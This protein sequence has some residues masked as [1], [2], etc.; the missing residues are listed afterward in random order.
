MIQ[1]FESKNLLDAYGIQCLAHDRQL[2]GNPPLQTTWCVVEKGG[3]TIPHLHVEPEV[4]IALSGSAEVQVGKEVLSFEKGDVVHLPSEVKHCVRNVSDDEFTFLSVYWPPEP[5]RKGEKYR[6]VAAPPT[7]NGRL[8]LGHISGPYL[9]AMALR[10][11]LTQQGAEVE[12]LCGSDDHQSYVC[13]AAESASKDPAHFCA[14]MK[15]DIQS[16]FAAAGIEWDRLVSPLQNESYREAVQKQFVQLV[17]EGVFRRK[18]VA[19]ALGESSGQELYGGYI[20]GQCP[21]CDTLSGGGLCEA[22]GLPNGSTDLGRFTGTGCDA[23]GLISQGERFVLPLGDYA[24]EL[25]AVLLGIEMPGQLRRKLLGIVDRGLPEMVVS[26]E[27]P[28]GLKATL[29]SDQVV[30]EWIEMALAYAAE[31]PH[32]RPAEKL[33]QCFGTDNAYYYGIVHLAVYLALGREDLI[34]HAF[35]V[36]HFLQL[37]GE[38]FSTSRSHAI[39][40]SDLPRSFPAEVLQLYL[41]LIRPEEGSTNLTLD[42]FLQFVKGRLLETWQPALL[43]LHWKSCRK[44]EPVQSSHSHLL[45]SGVVPSIENVLQ[46]ALACAEEPFPHW[47]RWVSRVERVFDLLN[48][49]NITSCH[50]FGAA[51]VLAQLTR[52]LAPLSPQ[53]ARRLESLAE[54]SQGEDDPFGFRSA[55]K[56]I[57]VL[58]AEKQG[59]V[60]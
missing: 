55:V 36:N 32:D 34:P 59:A 40:V 46:K 31:L 5:A 38:K 41:S 53:L 42:G 30:D 2:M 9:A 44:P 19:V 16:D 33:I 7:P 1:K 15:K 56:G 27:A 43:A 3:S 37:E 8:H 14:E 4:F 17:A 18:S 6:I 35:V 48:E 13:V 20:S 52:L 11:H 25:R 28:W 21:H 24:G 12:T 23:R 49:E 45:S 39:W 10:N 22:C 60:K 54:S 50:P 58:L 29:E 51:H 57:E 26:H 47:G